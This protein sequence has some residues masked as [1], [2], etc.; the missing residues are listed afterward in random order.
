[1]GG[2]SPQFPRNQDEQYAS[3]FQHYNNSY[4]Y[5]FRFADG[6][7]AVYSQSYEH[8]LTQSKT[9]NLQKFWRTHWQKKYSIEVVYTI[10]EEDYAQAR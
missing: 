3:N 5:G 6:K 7:T 8:S 1:M 9:P 10:D 2:R 4:F